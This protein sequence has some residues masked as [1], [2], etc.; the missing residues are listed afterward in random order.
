MFSEEILVKSIYCKDI[1]NSFLNNA[2]PR[3]RWYSY[4]EGF[5]QDIVIDAINNVGFKSSDYVLDPFNGNG[6]VT[7]TSA[8][9]NIKSIGIEINPFVSFMSKVKHY[10]INS[11]IFNKKIIGLLN[12]VNKQKTSNLLNFSTFSEYSGK[13]KWL[14]NSDVL[15]SF[16]GGWHYTYKFDT[17]CKEL[18][19]LAL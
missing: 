2:L 12:S 1:S 18:F 11:K 14:F 16:E 3:Y 10:N 4:K 13:N 8:F 9:N 19:Q 5:S 17:I 7:L 6:T 15:N